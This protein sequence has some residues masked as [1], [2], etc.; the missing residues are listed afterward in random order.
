MDSKVIVSNR[1]VLLAKYGS[2]GFT[3]INKALDKLKAADKKRGLNTQ[4]IFLDDKAALKKVKG[5]AVTSAANPKENKLAIDAIFKKLSPSY[6]M[7]LGA[8]D[9]VPHQNLDNTMYEPGADDDLIAW[10]D[11]PYACAATYSRDARKFIAPARVVGRLPD[12]PAATDPSYLVGLL[13]T[14]MNYQSR[15][16]DDYEGYF[17]LSTFSWKKSTQLSLTNVFGNIAKLRVSPVDGPSHP[18][19]LL[20]SRMH[21]INCH[22]GQ[23]SP[24]FQG[25]KGKAYPIALT[26][27]TISGKIT[28]GTVAAV[29]CCYGAELYEAVT[30]GVDLPI[31]QTYLAQG[32]YGYLGS[33]TIAYGPANIN[34]SADLICQYFLLHVMGGASLGRAALMARQ[35][36]VAEVGQMDPVDLKT[37]AQFYLLGDPSIHPVLKPEQEKSTH[38]LAKNADQFSRAERRTKM[39]DVAAFLEK[40]KPVVAKASASKL[41]AETKKSLENLARLAGLKPAL[42]FQSYAVKT[43]AAAKSL[44][45]K[46]A[47]I[48]SKYHVALGVPATAKSDKVNRAVAVVVKELDGRIVGYRIYEQR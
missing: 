19:G 22:G 16:L 40:T 30:L 43:P 23:A 35:Q 33:T 21:F 10:S 3:K 42:G 27:K 32:A 29:E 4:V 36:Y 6:L 47:A 48:P 17:G 1:S 25:Q 12:L 45:I 8:S 44:G 26:T 15:A 11:L 31:C 18:A 46:A 2:K 28:E 20:A 37:L 7:I 9:V 14:A 34:G 13:A 5:V 41:T 38:V 24:E 39:Q